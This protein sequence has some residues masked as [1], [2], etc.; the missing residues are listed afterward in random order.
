[1]SDSAGAVLFDGEFRDRELQKSARKDVRLQGFD[2][3]VAGFVK[4]LFAH[5]RF[6]PVYFTNE[7]AAALLRNPP[8]WLQGRTDRVRRVSA[9]DPEELRELERLILLSVGPEMI[10]FAWL[11]SRLHR[12]DW[13]IT[14][15]LHALSPAPRIRYFFTSSL[16]PLLG[17]HD[18]FVCPS[19]AAKRAMES[20]FLSVPEEIRICREIPFELP[21]IPFGV[22][23]GEH[24]AVDREAARAAQGFAASA[25][26]FLYFGRIA[27]DKADLLPLLMAFAQLPPEAGAVLVLAGDDTQLKMGPALAAVARELGCGERVQVVADVSRQAKLEL[28]AAADVFVSPSENTQESFPLT[29][30]EAMAS[31][32]PVVTSDWGSHAE[33]VEHG[34]TGLLVPTYLPPAASPWQTLTL[35]SGLAQ[36]NLLAM[37]TAVDV[38]HL[39]HDLRL[40]L[41]RPDLRAAMGREARARAAATLDW[42]AVMGQYDELW[43]ELLRR[44]GSVEARRGPFECSSFQEVFAGYPTSS[45]RGEDRVELSGDAVGATARRL[46]GVLGTSAYFRA[47]VFSRI[48]ETLEREGATRIDRLVE[49]AGDPAADVE[50]HIG[51]LVK[52]GILHVSVSPPLEGSSTLETR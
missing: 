10:Q 43:S 30:A 25:T 27:S 18:A 46:P 32:L 3:F 12:R 39:A 41:E 13:P 21:V 47:D 28:L 8:S 19:R 24:A 51:R 23:T 48:L 26:V 40:L 4:A 50:R 33:L 35:Y 2:V 11:R 44:A 29:L 38:G 9:N 20:L 5:S 36:E 22:D 14:A 17:P 6:G 42:R 49:L 52:Y 1:M 34:T 16:L 37:S 15:V 7:A 45:L 31:G